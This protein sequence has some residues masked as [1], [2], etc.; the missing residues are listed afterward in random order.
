MEEEIL[1]DHKVETNRSLETVKLK[2]AVL[3][4][5]TLVFKLPVLIGS[6]RVKSICLKT[7][8]MSNVY[9]DRIYQEVV[10][11]GNPEVV[12]PWKIQ[13]RVAELLAEDNF[14]SA[15]SEAYRRMLGISPM[16]TNSLDPPQ[17]IVIF[18]PLNTFT[19]DME[20]NMERFLK[21]HSGEGLTI[22]VYYERDLI[23]DEQNKLPVLMATVVHENPF[24]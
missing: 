11:S 9:R 14:S 1:Y 22:T 23:V 20:Q 3:D 12:V 5:K 2:C 21:D 10:L 8:S 16:N 19:A 17:Q 24:K 15:K 4:M 18:H 6:S 13:R 7:K